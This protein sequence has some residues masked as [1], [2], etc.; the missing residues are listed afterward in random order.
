M[1]TGKF[2]AINVH[3]KKVER[4]Q[5]NNLNFYLRKLVGERKSKLNLKQKGKKEIQN[6]RVKINEIE[7]RKTTRKINS[8]P[9]SWFFENMYKIDKPLAI[10]EK[11]KKGED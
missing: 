9:K 2:T 7:N 4:S 8:E 3:I 5:I 1:P 10:L 11:E 6:I